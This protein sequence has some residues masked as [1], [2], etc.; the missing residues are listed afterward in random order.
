MAQDYTV[1]IYFHQ[2][3]S[4]I[5]I[6][7]L[8]NGDDGWNPYVL[9]GVIDLYTEIHIIDDGDATFGAVMRSLML[10][11]ANKEPSY[12]HDVNVHIIRKPDEASSIEARY[13][14]I[15][16]NMKS[17]GMNVTAHFHFADGYPF[18]YGESEVL[19]RCPCITGT[20][21]APEMRFWPRIGMRV[22]RDTAT[23][24]IERMSLTGGGSR[25]DE[26]L[27]SSPQLLRL[28]RWN[29]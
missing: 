3:T 5:P 21:T 14:S 28:Q 23:Q 7:P 4:L 19:S 11:K 18:G 20:M 26:D 10:L 27:G 9:A 8:P 13:E 1:G 16:E 25:L 15:I 29:W 12:M 24:F 17:E 2:S 22:T 6:L